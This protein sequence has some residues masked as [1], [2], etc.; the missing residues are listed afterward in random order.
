MIVWHTECMSGRGRPPDPDLEAR[1]H[2][3]A[4]DLYGEV[5]W[6]GFSLDVV[7]RRARVGKAALYSRWGSKEK[8]I[9]DA[10]TAMHPDPDSHAP[11]RSG[12][13]REDL[14]VMAVNILDGYF[15]RRGLVILRAQIEAKVYPELFGHALER[16]QRE[17]IREGRA[18]VVSGIDRGELPAGTSPARVL[19]AVAGIL[20]NHV[21]STP[22]SQM[23]ALIK[24]KEKFAE[25]TVDFVL[26]A[27]GYR[28]AV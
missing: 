19:D 28:S 11:K 1:V 5:G 10:L 7:A 14:I 3:A 13:L 17:R 9:V 23:P 6:A 8:L 24:R 16:L 21:L 2:A 12:L 4:L 27:V 15:D 18:I 25:E 22:A 20:T 26:S